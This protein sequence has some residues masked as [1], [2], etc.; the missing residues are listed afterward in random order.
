M[1]A[2]ISTIKS[3]LTAAPAPAPAPQEEKDDI[4][5]IVALI[6]SIVAI[7]VSTVGVLIACKAGKARGGGKGTDGSSQM[8]GQSQL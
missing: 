2:D 5:G 6:I 3:Q 7:L 8:I 1:F 4:L